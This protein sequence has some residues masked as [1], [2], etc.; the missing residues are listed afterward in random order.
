MQNPSAP[1]TSRVTISLP[2]AL[3]RELDEH[4]AHGDDEASRSAVVQ[5]LIELALRYHTKWEQVEQYVR[6]WREQPD[7]LEEF[8]WTTSAPALEHL[9][10]IPWDPGAVVSGGPT[11]PPHRDDGQSF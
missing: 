8:G 10:E 6:G 1:T 2:T 3:L 7:T 4:L 5:R 11:S 9:G